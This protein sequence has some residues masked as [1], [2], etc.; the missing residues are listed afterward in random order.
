VDARRLAG[1]GRIVADSPS[2][3]PEERS[4][5]GHAVIDRSVRVVLKIL[6]DALFEFG[7][8]LAFC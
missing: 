7:R 1:S 3:R 5:R 2:S 4:E 6:V 8:P